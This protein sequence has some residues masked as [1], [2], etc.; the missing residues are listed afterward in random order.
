MG[1]GENDFNFYEK[2]LSNKI[3]KSKFVKR[4]VLLVESY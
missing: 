1:M 4:L 2:I 3:G